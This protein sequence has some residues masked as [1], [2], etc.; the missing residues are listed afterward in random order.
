MIIK[1]NG[2]N[3]RVMMDTFKAGC[4]TLLAVLT[5]SI[6][7][8]SIGCNTPKDNLKVFNTS[9]EASNYDNSAVFAEKKIGRRKNPDGEDLLWALQLASVERIRQNY[10]KSTEVFDK[11]E[12]MLKL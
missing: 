12:D 2:L 9:F 8:F 11:A 1:V 10:P 7:P 4:S 3:W 6:L 5:L